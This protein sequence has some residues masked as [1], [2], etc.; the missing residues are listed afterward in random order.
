M[1]NFTPGLSAPDYIPW[2]SEKSRSKCI[3]EK[4]PFMVYLL[5]SATVLSPVAWALLTKILDR[6]GQKT[7]ELKLG[8][9]KQKL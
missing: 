8:N 2:K 7:E 1:H 4:K 5:L 3:L 9:L 6:C